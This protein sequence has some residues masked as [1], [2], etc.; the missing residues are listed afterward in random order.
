MNNDETT[1]LGNASPRRLPR[2]GGDKK[3]AR[4]APNRT[5]WPASFDGEE[6]AMI[7]TLIVKTNGLMSVS[8]VARSAVRYAV[9]L[10]NSGAIPFKGDLRITPPSTNTP[11]AGS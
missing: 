6:L 8:E 3:R 7:K 11:A 2:R 9:P 10:M 1:S 5:S 4:K